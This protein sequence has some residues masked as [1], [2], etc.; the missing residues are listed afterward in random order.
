MSTAYKF[1]NPHG[2]YFVT[3]ATV[4]W[5]D[6]FVRRNYQ[7]ILLESLRY[8]IKNKG[9]VIYAWCLMP[10]H[11]HMIISAEGQQR[12]YEIIRDLKKYTSGNLLKAIRETEISRKSWMLWL[13]LSAGKE[14]PNNKNYQFWQQD[15]H[16]VEL[17]TNHFIDQKLSYIHNNPVEAGFAE[18]PEDYYLSSARDYN[19]KQGL[20]PILLI[21]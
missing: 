18:Y 2:L 5:V 14:N 16:P 17:E 1:N 19:G 15:N 20:L 12:P 8:C 4:Q 13:F 21:Q 10:G 7:E 3:F 11:I 9:L 6:V